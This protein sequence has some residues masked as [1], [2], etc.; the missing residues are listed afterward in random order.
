MNLNDFAH[1]VEIDE[2]ERLLTIYRVQGE[3]RH[4]YTSISLPD[5]SWDESPDDI[6]EFCQKL[7]ENII[8][9]SP[10]ARKLFGI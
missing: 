7:G 3:E 8:I 6:K 2:K 4:L 9:D 1:I 10:I 5:K